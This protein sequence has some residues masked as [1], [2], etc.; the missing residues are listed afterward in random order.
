MELDLYSIF[1]FIIANKIEKDGIIE[2]SKNVKYITN[3]SVLDIGG[4]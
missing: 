1:I 4:I 2:L 3:L